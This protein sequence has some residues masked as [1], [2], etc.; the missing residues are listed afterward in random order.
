M[1][2]HIPPT[3]RSI[4]YDPGYDF[5]LERTIPDTIKRS[6]RDIGDGPFETLSSIEERVGAVRRPGEVATEGVKDQSENIIPCC[7][8]KVKDLASNFDRVFL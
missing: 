5:F 2:Y 3:T 7:G 6:N 1:P 4:G 8:C